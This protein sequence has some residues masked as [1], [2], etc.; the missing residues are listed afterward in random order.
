ME[1]RNIY[2][3]P[4]CGSENL[5]FSAYLIQDVD[6]DFEIDTMDLDSGWCPSCD[7]WVDPTVVRTVEVE[8]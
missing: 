2:C 4:H 8:E 3:C 7:Y 1:E 6:G 5:E